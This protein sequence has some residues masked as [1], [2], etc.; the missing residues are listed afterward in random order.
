MSHMVSYD[1]MTEQMVLE[2]ASEEELYRVLRGVHSLLKKGHNPCDSLAV[3]VSRILSEAWGCGFAC[4]VSGDTVIVTSNEGVK[5]NV[6][7]SD[8]EYAEPTA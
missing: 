4:E 8:A 2:D 3:L 5:F 7:V 6:T 1:D